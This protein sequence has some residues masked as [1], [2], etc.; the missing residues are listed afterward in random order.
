[1]AASAADPS[2]EVKHIEKLYEFGERLNE[3]KDI[4]QNVE[5]YQ[6]GKD[7]HEGQAARCTAYSPGFPC[8]L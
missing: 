3:S 1:M 4:S 8:R 6:C 2:D 7:E 5:D